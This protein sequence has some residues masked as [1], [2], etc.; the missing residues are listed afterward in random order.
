MNLYLLFLVHF[1][2]LFFFFC[3][4]F[5]IDLYY[6]E[7]KQ[8][9]QTIIN[10]ISFAKHPN[11]VNE[12]INKIDQYISNHESRQLELLKDLATLSKC[13]Y[14]FD[15]T[16]EKY[17]E[18][19]ELFQSFFST[20]YQL[21]ALNEQLIEETQTDSAAPIRTMNIQNT[22]PQINDASSFIQH[23]QIHQQ[24][25]DMKITESKQQFILEESPHFTEKLCDLNVQEGE[26]CLL[27]CKVSSSQPISK[28]E[29]YRDG[30]PIT[31]YHRYLIRFDNN[32]CTLS[33]DETATEDSATFTCRAI[34]Q[35]GFDDTSSR[36][37]C[38]Q[39][40]QMEMLI[41]PNFLKVLNNLNV[42]DGTSVVWKCFVEGNPL[43]TVQWFKNDQCID[44]LPQY[45]FTY[46]NGESI[47][48]MDNLTIL[49]AGIY[50]CVAK[51]MLGVDQ[52]SATL[53]VTVDLQSIDSRTTNGMC[54][55]FNT[56]FIDIMFC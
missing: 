46:N 11:E 17:S 45:N 13:V 34:N 33:I 52:C 43:P 19:I 50:T 41:P 4:I 39:P 42:T 36:L 24:S 2:Y 56:Y 25:I 27:M 29:W 28:I 31:N 49:D 14:G 38:Q 8:Y 5:Q 9:L 48:C 32:L 15:K 37:I 22:E 47:L 30:I 23:Q 53:M 6:R 3:A 10:Q 20:K 18:N 16:I 55:K 40:E 26:R 7:H 44:V 35:L 54:S 12:L 51:N 1:F 21:N